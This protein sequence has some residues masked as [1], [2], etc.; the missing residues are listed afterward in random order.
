MY[1]LK[2]SIMFL[3]FTERWCQLPLI[4]DKF[5]KLIFFNWSLFQSRQSYESKA[6]MLGT[7]FPSF[8]LNPESKWIQASE[9]SGV[10]CTDTRKLK[11]SGLGLPSDTAMAERRVLKYVLDG[12]AST[13][14]WLISPLLSSIKPTIRPTYW[15]IGVPRCVLRR[16]NAIA[17]GKLRQ[18]EN[19]EVIGIS[20]ASFTCFS[21][22]KAPEHLN[23]VLLQKKFNSFTLLV[24]VCDS[25]IFFWLPWLWGTRSLHVPCCSNILPSRA[26]GLRN[27]LHSNIQ[28]AAWR[29]KSEVSDDALL[30]AKICF[31]RVQAIPPRNER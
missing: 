16:F 8:C 30:G 22:E 13:R 2:S 20:T 9:P 15:V 17:L 24:K 31:W 14:T 3:S 29:C 26:K 25:F 7:V 6:N 11:V 27:S 18:P 1:I 12:L 28:A 10:L 4:C 19:R 23:F 21:F 5:N